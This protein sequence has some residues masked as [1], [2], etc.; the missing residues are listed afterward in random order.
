METQWPHAPV[1]QLAESGTYFVTAGTYNKLHHFR[2]AERVAVLHRGLLALAQEFG[3]RLEAW[4]VFSNHYNF[5]A[6]S[7][8]SDETAESL[9]K[10]V[11]KLHV[12]TAKWVNRLDSAAGRQVWYNYRDTRLTYEKSYYARLHYVHHNAV[13]HGLVKVANQYPW[14]SAGWFES[15]ATPAQ[16]QTIYGMKTDSVN[17]FDEYDV[18][19]EW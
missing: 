10:M 12:E 5:V 19:P 13:K 1:H 3:W 7:P 8:A 9:K 2:G 11:T 15:N 4:A 6:N 18:S 14:C 16:V 17:V